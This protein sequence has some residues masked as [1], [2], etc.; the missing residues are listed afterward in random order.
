MPQPSL[1][2]AWAALARPWFAGAGTRPA[3]TGY[4]A[5]CCA[6]ALA[7]TLVS[8]RISYAQRRFSTALAEKDPGARLV[9]ADTAAAARSSGAAHHLLQLQ[10][11]AG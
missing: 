11:V 6:L 4:A 7:S 10:Q 3:A 1:L 5:G 9:G 8:V 2:A